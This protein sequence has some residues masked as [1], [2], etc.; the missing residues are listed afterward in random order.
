MLNSAVAEQ[1]QPWA[2]RKAMGTAYANKTLFTNQAVAACGCEP[3]I[4]DP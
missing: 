2:L 3:Y 4:V 1:K